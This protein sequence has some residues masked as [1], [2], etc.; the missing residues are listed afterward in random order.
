MSNPAQIR[1]YD[2]E[3][4]Q[5]T[6]K[7]AV[8]DGLKREPKRIAPKFFYDLKGSR[9]FNTI[10]EQPEYYLP[11]S[12]H[13]IFS[14]YADEIAALLGSRCLLIE[15]GA[16][17]SRKVRLFIEKLRPA[18]YAPMDISGDYL[19]AAAT[20]LAKDFPWLEIHASCLDFTHGMVL[21][22][23]LPVGRRVIF[24]PG[25]TLGNFEPDE[26]LSFLTRVA[27]L[28][29]PD[30]GL[31]IGVDTKKDSV[32][33]NEAYND[34]AGVTAAFNLNLL[35][36]I[37]RELGADF[38]LQHF[39]HLAFYNEKAGRIEMHLVSRRRQW[40][41]VN[42]NRFSFA[43]GE[44]IHTECSYKYDPKE[45]QAL[46]RRAGFQPVRCWLDDRKFFGVHYLEHA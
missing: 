21:P 27:Q 34:A 37:N 10:C 11:D 36:R 25:S 30:G 32:T 45:F 24:F 15:P 46:A 2:Y 23:G 7:E 44:R 41:N 9:L 38:E 13:S 42:N 22:K 35:S 43:E 12:E 26:A 18:A 28:V 19:L 17:A 39:D 8:L 33:L 3:S 20:A 1:F 29:G 14:C 31:L 6:L 16:G 4:E 5:L 40:V